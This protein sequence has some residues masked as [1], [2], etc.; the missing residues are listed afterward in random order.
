MIVVFENII[1]TELNKST[2]WEFCIWA[3]AP[4]IYKYPNL[5][6]IFLAIILSAEIGTGW[7]LLYNT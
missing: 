6:G 7:R 1:L 3:H 2:S 4:R 5:H